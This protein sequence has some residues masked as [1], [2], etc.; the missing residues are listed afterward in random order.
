MLKATLHATRRRMLL[1]SWA[2]AGA[3]V[4]GAACSPGG[5]WPPALGGAATPRLR[6]GIRLSWL[7]GAAPGSTGETAWRAQ[8]NSFEQANPGI[9]VELILAPGAERAAKRVALLAAGTPA[10]VSQV[11][12]SEVP[13]LAARGQLA[14]LGRLIAR[15]RFDLGDFLPP[16]YEQ[17]RWRGVLSAF[18][19]DYPN[20]P[21]VYSATLFDAAGVQRPP[22]DFKDD[23][24]DWQTF[25]N[26]A[27]RVSSTDGSA[28]EAPRLGVNFNRNNFRDWLPWLW[29]NGADLLTTDGSACALTEPAAVEALQFMA[30][31]IH[32]HRVMPS[33]TAPA[34]PGLTITAG[35]LGM[36]VA[37]PQDVGRFRQQAGESFLRTI[38]VIPHPKGKSARRW[39]GGGGSGW[40]V[41]STSAGATAV[42]E[43]WAMTKHVSSPELSWLWMRDTGALSPRRSVLNRPEAFTP[44]PEHIRLYAQAGE[45][46]HPDPQAVRW[47]EILQHVNREMA[48]LWNGTQPANAVAAAIKRQV[49][50]LLKD[51]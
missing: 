40:S 20:R 29:N 30:D 46:L 47:S 27:Q 36:A 18:P 9:T 4:L 45:Y 34:D 50:P 28:G 37:A 22:S 35:R 13:E 11:G 43:S 1:M 16:S 42:E 25:L 5:S 26:A 19:F 17:Y 38:D 24:W 8:L 21:L 3:S 10:D 23:R 44:P 2:A 33:P 6:T 31:L 15:D 51:Q 32:R 48:A 14:D 41:T 49:D 7:A 39:V 12:A